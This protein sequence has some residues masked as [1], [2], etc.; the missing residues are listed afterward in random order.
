MTLADQHQSGRDNVLL[1][2]IRDQDTER[3]RH[4][5]SV[6]FKPDGVPLR[7][8][9]HNAACYLRHGPT[10]EVGDMPAA[11]SAPY[12][13][14]E[15]VLP[16][17]NQPQLTSIQDDEVEDRFQDCVARFW[18]GVD[19]PSRNVIPYSDT[20]PAV[21]EAAQGDSVAIVDLLCD[22]G[23]DT[24]FWKTHSLELPMEATPSS[25]AISTPLHAA[26]WTRNSDMLDHLLKSGFCA[27]AMPLANP[28]KCITP[29]MA[30]IVYCN[31]WNKEAFHRLLRDSGS[32]G[33]QM[34]TPVFNVHILHFAV[35]R[36][37]PEL[38]R[39]V[40]GAFPLASAGVTA[41]G[42]T[43]LHIA[44][45]PL[46]EQYVEMHSQAIYDSIHEMR[47]LSEESAQTAQLE[48][49]HPA[50]DYIQ[51]RE[52]VQRT[53]GLL[54]SPFTAMPPR[55]TWPPPSVEYFDQQIETVES[56]YSLLAWVGAPLH[57]PA[58]NINTGVWKAV[59]L[60]LLLI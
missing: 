54:N 5:L 20:M 1:Q 52:N 8:L 21:I 40:S 6:G 49:R 56:E 26:V 48:H 45:L 7:L 17:I 15:H 25:L 23:A 13:Q 44:C 41:L 36:L 33:L 22:A 16:A 27:N 2:A 19:F 18:T 29:L 4:L 12:Y 3:V 24:S 9:S 60:I 58:K 53:T 10:L 46:N 59:R 57:D 32:A 55:F 30:T 11:L 50:D 38:L 37:D 14:R 35:A 51:A 43:L 34:R 39:C 28:T 47:S 42:H 31:P